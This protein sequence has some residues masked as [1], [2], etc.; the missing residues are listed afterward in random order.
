MN[1]PD[2]GDSGMNVEEKLARLEQ[3][4]SKLER[5]LGV[6]DVRRDH[7]QVP[8]GR[9]MRAGG[10]LELV[11]G[12][13]LFARVGILVMAIGVGLALSLTWHGMPAVM[14]SAVGWLLAAGLLLLAGRLNQS[15]PV[16]ARDLR[17]AGMALLFFATLRLCYFGE[18]CVLPH[19]SLGA[20]M[21]LALVVLVNLAIG[22]CRKSVQL[23]G[24]AILT[25]YAAALAVGKPWFMIGT[26]TIM[27]LF[28][29]VASVRREW[30]WLLVFATP[31]AFLTYLLWAIGNP[32]IGNTF[33]IV[34]DHSASVYVMLGWIA[35]IA[36]AMSM[37]RQRDIEI[38]AAQVSSVF[39][40][41]GYLLFMLHTFFGHLETFA[42]ANVVASAILLGIAVMFW[43]RERSRFAT[44]VY[45]MTGYGAL[46]LALIKANFYG[47]PI[48]FIW[49]S[50]QSLVVVT[51]AIWF[52]S[53]FI[54]VANFLIYL[55]I[56]VSY[57]ITVE[58]ETG[59]SL[60][61]GMVALATA[62]S[63]KLQMGRLELKTELMRNAY[64]TCAFV[65]FPYA[66]YHL[67]TS[68][69]VAF[70]WV[71]IALLY[72]LMNLLTKARKYRWLGHNTLLLTVIYVL[73]MGVGNSQGTQ[74]IV[75]FIVLGA[76]LMVVS[77]LF[78]VIRAR[79][80]R[81]AS[82]ERDTKNVDSASQ[83]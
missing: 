29:A 49:L 20:W 3:R 42:A 17:P 27:V 63:L 46:S 24:F 58:K 31:G 26:V 75:S 21:A 80:H 39:N 35:L 8:E 19:D 60:V 64:L 83:E 15:F 37:R 55:A 6:A 67:V 7:V 77:L 43:I 45:A 22:W 69:W 59:I 74:R 53:R 72:Y 16:I 11:V 78:T 13:N 70:S 82:P 68:S 52:R 28:S 44:F 38:P 32:A 54:V 51:T 14:P 81:I 65:V 33:G 66:L 57:M 36:V 34:K 41:G 23:T 61:F 4:L 47:G 40:C 9:S 62:R 73:V 50:V 10:E 5:M 30:P 18:S 25:G 2:Q 76:V 71:G 48:V 12:Q 56:V 1:D 79:Q